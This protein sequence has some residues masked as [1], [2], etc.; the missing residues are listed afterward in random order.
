MFV[1]ASVKLG[2]DEN[3]RRCGRDWEYGY[4]HADIMKIRTGNAKLES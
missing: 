1:I 2:E 3:R 4:R